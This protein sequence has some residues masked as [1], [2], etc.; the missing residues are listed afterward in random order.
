MTEYKENNNIISY[1]ILPISSLSTYT[2]LCI[3]V[4]FAFSTSGF[5]QVSVN[6][7]PR[8][9]GDGSQDFRLGSLDDFYAAV[10]FRSV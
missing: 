10:L 9:A 3:S 1:M 2:Q 6:T 4:T 8:C 7:I 5:I